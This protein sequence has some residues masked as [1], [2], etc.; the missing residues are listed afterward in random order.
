MLADR[1]EVFMKINEVE[2]LTGLTAKSIRHYEAKG[3]IAISRE[4]ANGYRSYTEE[5]V[6]HLKRIKL[7]RYLE[8]GIEE[9]RH[10]QELEL[11]EIQGILQKQAEK[12]EDAGSICDM[13]KTLCQSLSRDYGME[14]GMLKE[15]EETIAFLEGEEAAE[16]RETVKDFSCPSTVQM[17]IWSLVFGAP[18]IGLFVNIQRCYNHPDILTINALF[19]LLGILFLTLQW[20]TYFQKRKYQ[21]A[22]MK[23]KGRQE[24]W[25]IPA[26]L[27]TIIVGIAAIVLINELIIRLFAPEGWLFYEFQGSG[28]LVLILITELPF[29]GAVIYLTERLRHVPERNTNDL[30]FLFSILWKHKLISAGVWCVLF[31]LALVNVTFVTPDKIICYSTLHPTGMSYSYGDITKAKACFGWKSI[32]I[33]EYKKKG[34]F[35]YCIYFDEKEIVFS[36]PYT[37]DAVKRYEDTYLELEEFDEKVMSLGVPKDGSEEYADA[38]DFDK[39]YVDRF[40]RIVRN[41]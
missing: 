41:K 38:C 10:I 1:N 17:V 36:Q 8:F 30:A 14:N 9:I 21:K 32:A 37:N 12:F 39:R 20:H 28:E 5:D 15:Y 31:Y 34:T 2:K 25:I 27:L 18:V 35:S 16:L 3:L 40:L 33:K 24:I 7:L 4:E 29:M 19:A 13:K 6:L 26:M 23:E 22:R 11:R